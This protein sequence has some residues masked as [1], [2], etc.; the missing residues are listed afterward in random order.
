MVSYSHRNS[1]KDFQ[2][3]AAVALDVLNQRTHPD[4]G[5]FGLIIE[6]Q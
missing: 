5:C 3:Q 4:H 2:R 6:T 1:G